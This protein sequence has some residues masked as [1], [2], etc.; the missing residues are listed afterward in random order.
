MKSEHRHDLKTNE[1]ADWITHFPQWAKENIKTI[2]YVVVL[3]IVVLGLTIYKQY[4]KNVVRVNREIE[5]SKKIAMLPMAKAQ[6]LDSISRGQEDISYKLLT[7]ADTTLKDTA[8]MAKNDLSA[9]LAL[10]T[11]ADAMRA[12]LYYSRKTMTKKDTVDRLTQAK[13]L[14]VEAMDLADSAALL[15]ANAKL[16][17]GLCQEEMGNIDDAK[18]TYAE[19]SSDAQF[20]GT[21]AAAQAKD[22]LA[23]MDDYQKPVVFKA[24][25][26]MPVMPEVN[27]K[28]PLDN[29]EIPTL[30]EPNG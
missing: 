4:N 28:N 13:S 8:F 11:R 1:L 10:M 14:Y 2:I 15:K 23:T 24:P 19:L 29:L 9:A 3:I 6:V 18:K 25:A 27:I 17:I 5:F 21:T 20:A 12:E 22:R 26:P 16:G 30:N 7:Y